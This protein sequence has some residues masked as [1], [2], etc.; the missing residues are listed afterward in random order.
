M[1]DRLSEFPIVYGP[2][3]D[4]VPMPLHRHG[5]CWE[6]V[7]ATSGKG[8]HLLENE[9]FSIESGDVFVVA[10]DVLHGYADCESLCLSNPILT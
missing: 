7:I 5:A 2:V 6:L 9:T 8:S 1:S 4:H 10:V 3:Q